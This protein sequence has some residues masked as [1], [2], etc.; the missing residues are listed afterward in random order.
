[1]PNTIPQLSF[2]HPDMLRS[3]WLAPASAVALLRRYPKLSERELSHLIDIFQRTPALEIALM[4]IDRDVGPRLEA[5][6]NEH[7]PWL[8]VPRSSFFSMAIALAGI[9]FFLCAAAAG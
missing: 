5:F 2:E 9:I 8:R 7:R 6:C 3:R 1:M 4:M